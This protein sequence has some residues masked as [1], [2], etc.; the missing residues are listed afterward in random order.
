[1]DIAT[2]LFEANLVAQKRFHDM[3]V[4]ADISNPDDPLVVEY[5][6]SERDVDTIM[7]EAQAPALAK[8]DHYARAD[9][10]GPYNTAGGHEHWGDS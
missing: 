9:D 8:G 5:V 4:A 10:W 3:L 2:R 6:Q 1:M 7:A